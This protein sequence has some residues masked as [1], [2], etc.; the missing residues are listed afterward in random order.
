[1]KWIIVKFS[2][3]ERIDQR[4]E[5]AVKFWVFGFDNYWWL[6]RNL[7][8][9]YRISGVWQFPWTR[10]HF[11]VSSLCLYFEK[12]KELGTSRWTKYISKD[13]VKISQFISSLLVYVIRESYWFFVFSTLEHLDLVKHWNL[14]STISTVWVLDQCISKLSLGCRLFKSSFDFTVQNVHVCLMMLSH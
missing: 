14:P 8:I 5:K 10:F 13:Q 12:K 3:I 9:G 4:K 2:R 1:M 11:R 6:L 7:I